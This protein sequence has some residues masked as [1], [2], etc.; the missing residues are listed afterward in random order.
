LCVREGED[1]D[2]IHDFRLLISLYWDLTLRRELFSVDWFRE[3]KGLGIRALKNVR[4]DDMRDALP[5]FLERV[6]RHVFFLLDSG[7]HT[8]I[9]NTGRDY[10]V[11]F[12]PLCLVNHFSP[13]AVVLGGPTMST[14]LLVCAEEG[15]IVR[16]STGEHRI[17]KFKSGPVCEDERRARNYTFEAGREVLVDYGQGMQ[18][19]AIETV[20]HA[21]D[22]FE[23][24]FAVEEIASAVEN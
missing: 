22:T 9:Y 10:F 3:D 7:G 17:L 24:S 4:Y 14:D 16:D 5:G 6:P 19:I 20:R 1:E 18:S 13:T 23:A 11:L 21:L 15:K 8:S 12:G 2:L